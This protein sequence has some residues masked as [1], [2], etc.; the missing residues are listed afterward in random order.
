MRKC[1]TLYEY[2][3]LKSAEKYEYS[4]LD[5]TNNVPKKIYPTHNFLHQNSVLFEHRPMQPL[6][7]LV[8]NY[9]IAMNFHINFFF[10][11]EKRK[12]R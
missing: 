3:S 11:R 2:F 4:S 12:L 6:P 5:L 7:Q 9:R 1:G 8:T 10:R